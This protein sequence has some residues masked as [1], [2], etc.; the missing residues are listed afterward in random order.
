[1]SSPLNN[2]QMGAVAVA[3][4]LPTSHED[5]LEN[6]DVP[7]LCPPLSLPTQVDSRDKTGVLGG[8]HRASSKLEKEVVVVAMMWP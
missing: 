6:G 1:M 4:L 8:G 2:I 7:G 5:E 3:I